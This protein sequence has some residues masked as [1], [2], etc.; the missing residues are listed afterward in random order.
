MIKRVINIAQN[1]VRKVRVH[2]KK[3]YTE[4]VKN[5]RVMSKN[6]KRMGSA[7]VMVRVF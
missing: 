4:R 3:T 5:T 6:N 7:T 1:D 2:I